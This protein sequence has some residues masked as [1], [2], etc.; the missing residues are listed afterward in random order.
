MEEKKRD[1][2]DLYFIHKMWEKLFRIHTFY[3]SSE[4]NKLLFTEEQEKKK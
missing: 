4:A 3:R 2:T 1:Y